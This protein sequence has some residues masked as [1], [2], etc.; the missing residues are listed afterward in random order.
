MGMDCSFELLMAYF[1]P[2]LLF[3]QIAKMA[4]DVL[5]PSAAPPLWSKK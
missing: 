4:K 1:L 3:T 5:M 2:F